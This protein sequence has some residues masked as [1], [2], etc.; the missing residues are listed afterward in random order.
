MLGA[1]DVLSRSVAASE[2]TDATRWLVRSTEAVHEQPFLDSLAYR[3]K[4]P[5][6]G[7]VVTGDTEPCDSVVALAGGRLPWSAFAGTTGRRCRGAVRPQGQTGTT[8][9]ALMAREV[10][11]GKLVLVQ[12][13]TWLEGEEWE[14]S[15]AA[16]AKRD[17]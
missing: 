11:V 13:R 10:E 1:L 7:I 16:L 17:P 6:A 9:V 8:G 5:R 4:I 12:S 15:G 3:I 14:A 2:E